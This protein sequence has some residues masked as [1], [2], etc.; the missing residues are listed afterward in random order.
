[1]MLPP[2]L[3]KPSSVTGLRRACHELSVAISAAQASQEMQQ[4]LIGHASRVMVWRLALEL[5][6]TMPESAFH[7]GG[8]INLDFH[9]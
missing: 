3:S 4:A 5:T 7:F 2:D 8:V 6:A 1:M 9:R